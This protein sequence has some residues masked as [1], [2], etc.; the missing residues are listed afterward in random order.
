MAVRGA[1]EAT[2]EAELTRTLGREAW[3]R[4]ATTT[5]Y[6]HGTITR[7]VVTGASP[8][9][10]GEQR[11]WRVPPDREPCSQRSVVLEGTRLGERIEVLGRF[12]GFLMVR[13][14]GGVN[15][16]LAVE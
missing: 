11:A 10:A 4:A 14:P 16:W 1:I 13:T 12:E 5:G 7:T 2:T 8:A 15:G 9:Q 6:R 3:E